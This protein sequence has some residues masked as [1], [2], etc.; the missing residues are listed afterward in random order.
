MTIHTRTTAKAPAHFIA[1]REACLPHLKHYHRDLLMHDRRAIR[2]FPDVPYL[3]VTRDMGTHLQFMRPTD[4]PSWP[5]PGQEVPYLFST[6]DRDHLLKE[7]E[8][9]IKYFIASHREESVLVHHYD[10]RTLRKISYRHADDL[11]SRWASNVRHGWNR[12]AARLP[13]AA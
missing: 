4:H 8:G 11:L 10:G 1:L 13:A 3:H 2:S 9:F 5:A 6:A 12:I 7:A